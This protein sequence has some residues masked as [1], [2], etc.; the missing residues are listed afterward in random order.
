MLK[1]RADAYSAASIAPLVSYHAEIRH[2]V[3][4]PLYDL[5]LF[6]KMR[7]RKQEKLQKHLGKFI[8]R[9]S[10]VSADS[11]RANQIFELDSSI[12]TPR[13]QVANGELGLVI[14]TNEEPPLY[15]VVL[16]TRKD[17]FDSTVHKVTE[18]ALVERPQTEQISD[19][20]RAIALAIE[21]FAKGNLHNPGGK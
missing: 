21:Q 5:W 1:S 8:D 11:V 17:F 18:V 13:G 2:D 6:R 12:S 15:T 16:P 10:G 9:V 3:S 20:T 14:K 7:E 19:N 4:P